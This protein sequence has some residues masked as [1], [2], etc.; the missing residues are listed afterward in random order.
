MV[1][2]L[3]KGAEVGSAGRTGDANRRELIT[4]FQQACGAVMA[5][6]IE[7]TAYYR[8]TH[9]LPLCEVGSPASRFALPPANFHAWADEQQVQYPH[10]MTSLTTHDTKRSEDVRAR[11][12]VLSEAAE[13]WDALVTR[14][15]AAT[16]DLKP[17]SLDGRTENL[18]WQTLAGTSDEHSV[19]EWDRLEGYLIK[20]MREAKTHTTWTSVD[21]SLRERRALVRAG[22]PC[23]SHRAL[24]PC[25][26]APSDGGR[27]ACPHPR[28]EGSSRLT[29]PGVPDVYQ[30]TETVAPS[31][32]DPDNRRPVDFDALADTLERLQGHA[33]PR[34][35]AEEKAP[36]DVAHAPGA[37]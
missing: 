3:L 24:A 8:W 10:G 23:R 13:E 34:G 12:S 14:L 5:K 35:L 32:V 21:E 27:G 9:L 1:V 30:G 31:L 4:R 2:D 28:D 11:L 16:A 18:W 15:Q 20:A 26:M 17:S 6:G 29:M 37:A 33:K 36:R 7:D 25:R 19:M 22:H